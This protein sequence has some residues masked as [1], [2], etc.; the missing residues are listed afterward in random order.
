M[1]KLKLRQS[2]MPIETHIKRSNKERFTL[3]KKRAIQNAK[4]LP[5]ISEK[6]RMVSRNSHNN[7]TISSQQYGS[8][9]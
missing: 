9:S 1:K 3:A 2:A 7:S 5:K 8:L 6:V 4:N